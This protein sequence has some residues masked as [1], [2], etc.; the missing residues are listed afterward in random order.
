[1]RT[2]EG[3]NPGAWQCSRYPVAYVLFNGRSDDI[4]LK[5]AKVVEEVVG[6]KQSGRT[7]T[8]RGSN[9][10]YYVRGVARC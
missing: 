4:G 5:L 1:M 10:E 8:R 9:G 3:N 2:S 7:A 6:T